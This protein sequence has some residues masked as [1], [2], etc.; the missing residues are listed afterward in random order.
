MHVSVLIPS[1]D[2]RP[3]LRRAVRGALAQEGV[4]L[5]VIVVD[6]GSRE[7]LEPLVEEIGDE[8]VRVLRHP[9]SLGVARARNHAV[10]AARAPWVAFLDDDD[11]WAPEHLDRLTAVADDGVAFAFARHYLL[12]ERGVV[13]GRGPDPP[14]A[15]MLE[16][17]L[18]GNPV[19]T[20][21]SVL[22]RRELVL[23]EGGFDPAF[24][25]LADWDLWL[26]LAQRG[27][28]AVSGALSVAYLQHP[29]SMHR[30]AEGILSEHGALLREPFGRVHWAG[31]E[32][33]TISHGAMDGAVRSGERAAT[34]ILTR[35]R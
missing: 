2:R 32:T 9:T 26:R 4:E 30:D 17:L 22:A 13:V 10:E 16:Q 8:R 3:L 27:R 5:E 19:V 20:P 18:A 6:D 23:D 24:S 14:G 21:S 25:I 28:V 29:E 15:A 34:E 35:V 7:P 12:D 31:T 33:A 11:Q 1:R